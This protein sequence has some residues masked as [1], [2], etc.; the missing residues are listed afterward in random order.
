MR[1]TIAILL[2]ATLGG[3]V[4]CAPANAPTEPVTIAT[5]SSEVSTTDQRS[6]VDLSGG[7]LPEYADFGDMYWVWRN[8]GWQW[9]TSFPEDPNEPPFIHC[10]AYAIVEYEEWNGLILEQD[11]PHITGTSLS[12]VMTC[13]LLVADPTNTNWWFVGIRTD[14]SFE[15]RLQGDEIRLVLNQHMSIIATP[16]PNGQTLSGTLRLRIDPRPD[17]APFWIERPLRVNRFNFTPC[18]SIVP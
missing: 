6:P 4:A 18:C 2:A 5:S 8:G 10:Q 1:S 7:W 11:G 3:A 9:T 17:F 13:A 15:G 12:P 14:A 16:D